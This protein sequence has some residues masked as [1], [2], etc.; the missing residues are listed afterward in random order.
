VQKLKVGSCKNK[1]DSEDLREFEPVN[2][3]FISCQLFAGGL[4]YVQ[5]LLVL[6]KSQHFIKQ[7]IFH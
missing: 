4:R 7:L 6:D 3:D 5:E 2:L 1:N